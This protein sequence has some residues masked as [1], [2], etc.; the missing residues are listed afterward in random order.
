MVRVIRVR[1]DEGTCLTVAFRK[2]S[3]Y[4][5]LFLGLSCNSTI[6]VVFFNII[7][8]WSHSW[9]RNAR[10]YSML[11]IF[12]LNNICKFEMSTLEGELSNLFEMMDNN[13]WF[14]KFILFVFILNSIHE[15]SL[16]NIHKYILEIFVSDSYIERIESSIR[17][18]VSV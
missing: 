3:N 10:R 18:T 4:G 5:D 7:S 1:N 15:E 17:V 12:I 6:N 9:S 2:S 8:R 11:L 14:L 13:G 16:W